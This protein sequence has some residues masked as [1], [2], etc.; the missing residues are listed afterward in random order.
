[1]KIKRIVRLTAIILTLAMM[2][3]WIFGCGRV[4]AKVTDRLA[5]L[6]EGKFDA[7]AD[8]G[9]LYIEKLDAEAAKAIGTIDSLGTW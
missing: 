2:P 5:T 7:K 8:S 4:D 1:M 3:L 9:E 6:L